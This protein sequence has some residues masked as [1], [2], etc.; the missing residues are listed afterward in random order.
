MAYEQAE[1]SLEETAQ[2][3]GVEVNAAKVRL[4]RARIRLKEKMETHFV[5]EV[6]NL[7]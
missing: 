3:L 6:R 1:Q 4:H 5:E 7:N 2:V